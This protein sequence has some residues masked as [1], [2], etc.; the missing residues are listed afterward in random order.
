[1]NAV[2]DTEISEAFSDLFILSAALYFKLAVWEGTETGPSMQA[3][4]VL[5]KLHDACCKMMAAS[6][7]FPRTTSERTTQIRGGLD[8]LAYGL[9]DVLEIARA[10]SHMEDTHE[11]MISI[12]ELK[13]AVDS[14][15]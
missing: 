6:N 9:R 2:V 4:G 8:D 5:K 3:S 1:M 7:N 10:N 12:A 14:L 11:L 13:T 15:N